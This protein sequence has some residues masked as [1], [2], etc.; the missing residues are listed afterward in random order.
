MNYIFGK[1]CKKSIQEFRDLRKDFENER[2]WAIKHQDLYKK[3]C[4][5]NDKLGTDLIITRDDINNTIDF[6]IS[7]EINKFDDDSDDNLHDAVL[8]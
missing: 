5:K 4:D 2:Q 3:I 8:V 7:Y 1:E 6:L